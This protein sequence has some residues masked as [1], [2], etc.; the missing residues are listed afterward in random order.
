[1]KF[2]LVS[3]VFVFGSIFCP[4][5]YSKDPSPRELH[6]IKC[7]DVPVIDGVFDDPAWKQG[8]EITDFTEFRP[9]IGDKEAH[10]ERTVAYLM[11]ND[12]GIYF[13]GRCYE[14]STDRISKELKGR[15]G[16]GANDYIGIIFDTYKD[17]LNGFEYF[18]TPLGEQWDAKMAPSNNSNNGGEDFSWNA[19]WSSAAR[20]HDEGWDFEMFIPF[21]AIRFG[22]GDVQDWGLNITRRRRLTEE[23]FTW[24]P[25]DPT[26]NGFLT[27]EGYWKGLK[28]IKPP[29]RLQFSPYFS[30][31]TNHYPSQDALTKN[32][33]SQVNGGLDLK[34]GIN[35]AFTLD[36]VLIPDFGQV[37]SDNQVLNL[38][39]F[40][41]KFNEN[42]NFFSEGTEL[43]NKGG[44][45]YSRRIGGTPLHHGRP[46]ESLRENEYILKNPA[47]T[48]LINAAKISG[49][50]QSGLGI[51]FLNAITKPQHA[52]IENRSSGETREEMTNPLTNYNFMV[53]DQTLKNNSS[54][55]LVNSSVMREGGDYDSNVSA[56][57]FDFND[58]SNT[59]NVNGKVALSQYFQND[60]EDR[61]GTAYNLGFGKVSGQFSFRFWQEYADERYSHNDLGYFT[62]NNFLS[63]G[64]YGT[65]RIIKPKGW[66]NRINFNFNTSV[67][68]LA[69][70]IEDIDA[71]YQMSNLNFNVNA[72]TKKL[73]FVGIFSGF[74]PARNDFW[75]PRVTG[76]YFRRGSRVHTG[77]WLETNSAKK[78]SF[79]TEVFGGQFI[80][81][82]DI[83]IAEVQLNQT[84][85]FS[86][87]FSLSH[88]IN[89]EHVTN[90]IGY[91]SELPSGEVVMGR[92]NINTISNIL[93]SKYNFNTKM[94]INLRVRHYQS[95]VD[96]NAYYHLM[97]DGS[98]SPNESFRENTDQNVNFF[99]VDMVYTW[100]F[101]PGSFLNLVWKDAA[102]SSEDRNE[103]RYVRNLNN[104]L[105]SDHNNNLSLKVIY[106]LDY[107]QLKKRNG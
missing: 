12:I 38:S 88:N 70:R 9:K 37:Q 66:Y 78:Y 85:R 75:E 31:Y 3:I 16:F 68:H 53:L 100:Q 29:V 97:T 60:S 1:M 107:L 87:R 93:S 21:S 103:S 62:N 49:R 8:H 58:K 51:G 27:Q 71:R 24:N 104:I 45:F 30:I 22:N 19:V 11:Y 28:N 32:W 86:S 6:A 64:V 84:L 47:E 50:A 18:V 90:S 80:N 25:I 15:D 102:F 94:G 69:T 13:G 55:S 79:Y 99:N 7:Q 106:F 48:K 26:V 36:A 76:Q 33:T 10:A 40:E 14:P 96:Y 91:A 35:Q 34:Y 42:R 77:F 83:K 98:L 5:A 82:Y 44:L 46:G 52:I 41:V 63:H 4:V 56:F 74:Q 2:V 105:D 81:F 20:I 95:G 57:L 72:Q 59:W 65:Y 101:A 61:P 43:F 23:Q 89:F 73:M 17:N 39:P 54:I 92:R 67:S